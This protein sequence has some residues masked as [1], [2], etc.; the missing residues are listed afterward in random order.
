[1]NRLNRFMKRNIKGVLL[2]SLILL[3]F[4]SNGQD[5]MYE[6]NVGT[7]SFDA[8][9]LRYKF[10]NENR[11]FRISTTHL[12]YQNRDLNGSE[13]QKKYMS[14]GLM[15]GMEFPKWAVKRTVEYY[16]GF[17]FGGEFSRA[18]EVDENHYTFRVNPVLGVSYYF[19]KVLKLGVEVSHGLYYQLDDYSENTTVKNYGF[20]ISNG[21]AEI[22]L[23]FRF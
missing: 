18:F 12:S 3:F 8:F 7:S 13:E 6:V 22:L 14:L 19:N 16:Y 1:M 23:G 17:E 9:S 21:F 4:I 2:V 15:M 5:K 10:G 11:L 20:N